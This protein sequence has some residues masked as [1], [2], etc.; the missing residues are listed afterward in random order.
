VSAS[1]NHAALAGQDE[2][3]A[4]T[5]TTFGVAC[6]GRRGDTLIATTLL[7]LLIAGWVTNFV[8]IKDLSVGFSS[9]I[10]Q[11]MPRHT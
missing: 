6:Q 10:A 11:A 8:S 1:R 3:E 5:R 9:L 2:S 4:G 7:V